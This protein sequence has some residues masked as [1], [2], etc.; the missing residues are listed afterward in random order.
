MVILKIFTP[1]LNLTSNFETPYFWHDFKKS[2]YLW[3]F[4]KF[5]PPPPTWHQIFKPIRM[6]VTIFISY[7]S[8]YIHNLY[9]YKVWRKLKVTFGDRQP[10]QPV[11]PVPSVPSNSPLRGS[12]V[13]VNTGPRSDIVGMERK[14]IEAVT[15]LIPHPIPIHLAWFFKNTRT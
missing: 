7:I 2:M 10:V 3:L 6:L 11:Q 8:R 13:R 15:S 4:W 12:A 5:L 14:L 1:T 9:T